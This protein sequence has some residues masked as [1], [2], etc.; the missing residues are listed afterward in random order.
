VHRRVTQVSIRQSTLQFRSLVFLLARGSLISTVGL[1]SISN[2]TDHIRKWRYGSLSSI[3]NEISPL[4]ALF[5][6]LPLL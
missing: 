1:E 5:E 6:L 2:A 4:P 3:L